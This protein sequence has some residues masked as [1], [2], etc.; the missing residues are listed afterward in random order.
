MKLGFALDSGAEQV[1]TRAA[2]DAGKPVT[3]FETLDQ[4]LGYFAGLSDK[5]QVVYLTGVIDEIDT[6]GKTVDG[7]VA[8]WS[9]GDPDGLAKL[10]NDDL[11]DNPELA[12]TLLA[13]RNA[14]WADWIAARMDQAGD[15]VHRG[16]RGASGGQGQRAGQA[17]GAGDD[18]R[19]DRLLM[20]RLARALGGCWRWSCW[21]AA[22]EQPAPSGRPGAVAGDRRRHGDLAVRDDPPAAARRALA[23]RGRWRRRS[24]RATR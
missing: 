20:R 6:V 11:D 13:D 10:L 2:K 14:R 16:R 18:G 23:A 3:G 21:P 12:K 15:G 19:A 4:Q 17:G 5:A 9:K 7:M 1:L 24:P 8:E 22:R